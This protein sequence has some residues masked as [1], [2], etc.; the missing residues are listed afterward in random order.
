MPEKPPGRAWGDASNDRAAAMTERDTAIHAAGSLAVEFLGRQRQDEFLEGFQ[1]QL[2]LFVRTVATL[3]LEESGNLT[4]N[5][6][7]MVTRQPPSSRNGAGLHAL[8]RQFLLSGN[9]CGGDGLGLQVEQCA[10]V[11][12]RHDLDEA[13]QRAVPVLQQVPGSGAAGEQGLTT[14][15]VQNRTL[16]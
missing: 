8:V 1:P 2:S 6:L 11:I 5:R 3:D 16:S 12:A 4:H 9:S 10:L 15:F 7:Q 13:G 14:R